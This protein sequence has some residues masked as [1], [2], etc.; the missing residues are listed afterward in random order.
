MSLIGN[1]EYNT[2]SKDATNADQPALLSALS[3]VESNLM[4]NIT[5]LKDEVI[6]LNEIIIKNQ[7]KRLKTKVNVLENKIIDLE[8]QNNNLDQYSRRNNVEISGISQSVR[9]SH[10]EEKV[11]DILKAIDANVT[12][13]EIDACHRLGNKNK[14]VIFRAINRKHH[15]KALRNKKKLKSIDKNAIGTPNANLFICEN[16]T[17]ANSKL[18]FNRRKLK[19]DGKIE[20][21]YTVNGIVH[22]VKNNKLM[23]LY[24]L[25]DL[26]KL[27]PEYVFDNSDH[28]E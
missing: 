20:K 18:A 9:D 27:F 21:C 1:H 25:K 4:Q 17:P 3:K 23:K 26:H 28:A 5:N 24:H 13:N 15:L 6:N 19:R 8:I 22:I 16:L 2:R 14:N 11:V 12:T 7:N 10:L